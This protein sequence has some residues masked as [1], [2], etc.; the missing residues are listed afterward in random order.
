MWPPIPTSS[1]SSQ[2]KKLTWVD[3]WKIDSNYSEDVPDDDW[4]L[5]FLARNPHIPI[6]IEESW[7]ET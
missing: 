3:E 6:P 4:V 1:N 5:D 2:E 7:V